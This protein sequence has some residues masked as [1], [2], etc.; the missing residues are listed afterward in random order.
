LIYICADRELEVISFNGGKPIKPPKPPFEIYSIQ[1]NYDQS[2]SIR[3]KDHLADAPVPLPEFVKSVRNGPAA[4]VVGTLPHIKV[5]LKKLPGFVS[6][7]YAIGATG[8]LGGVRRKTVTPVFNPSGLSNPIDIELMW[9]LPGAVG[10][11]EVGLNWYARKS[12]GPSIPIS[13]GSASHRLYLVIA[14]ST[15]PWVTEIPWVAALEIAC[16]WAAGAATVDTAATRITERYYNCGVLQYDVIGGGGTKY[17]S[18]TY[19]LS[20]MVERLN[21]GPG[22]GAKV[23]CTDSANTVSTLA[24]LLGCDL[25]QSRMEWGFD[26]NPILAIGF[27]PPNPWPNW[28]SFSY[29]EIAWKG[30]C[31]ENDTLFD[32]CL[33]VDGDNDPTTT[34]HEWLLPTNMLFGDCTTMSYRLRLCPPG[35]QGCDQC[36]PQPSTKQRRPIH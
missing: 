35:Q 31:T 13:V 2:A 3:L 34:P 9:P 18:A 11:P 30:A 10:K 17:G 26:L 24:N 21:G 16:G 6:G 20:E 27:P 5:V 8:S 28:P 29:H 32:G 7:A 12:P 14:K 25:W 22:L 4:Y 36:Q 1:F 15:E 33:M 23:N 19:M